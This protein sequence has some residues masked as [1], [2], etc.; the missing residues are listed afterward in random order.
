M[1]LC[2][3]NYNMFKKI[4]IITALSI[5]FMPIL[6]CG[7][8]SKQVLDQNDKNIKEIVKY[9]PESFSSQREV[10]EDQNGQYPKN[11]DI[12][13]Y[14]SDKYDPGTC[15]GIPEPVTEHELKSV[16]QEEDKLALYFKN[17]YKLDSD[18]D[19]FL[20]IKKLSVII[21]TP[22]SGGKFNYEIKD[23][24]CCSTKIIKGEILNLGGKIF[25][26]FK[27]EKIIEN[28]C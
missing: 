11:F 14:L 21:L 24:Q 6:G 8:S 12:L 18:I 22:S 25:E 15:F 1:L 17:K 28:P 16:L 4:V 20:K 10:T 23:G 5:G 3:N 7:N 26:E 19:I 27:S 13:D 9:Y 2:Y